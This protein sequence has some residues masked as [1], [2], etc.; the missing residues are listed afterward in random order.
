MEGEGEAGGE[1]DGG[2]SIRRYDREDVVSRVL[3]QSELVAMVPLEEGLAEIELSELI[4]RDLLLA[5]TDTRSRQRLNEAIKSAKLPKLTSETVKLEA[6]GTKVLVAFGSH[7][8]GT[9]VVPSDIAYPFRAGNQL[10]GEWAE[11]FTWARVTS[12]GKPITNNVF[13]TTRRHHH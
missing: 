1:G 2:A 8:H 6:Y 7:K 5:P 13:V 12:E 3:Y 10:A 4:K 9:V 11:R